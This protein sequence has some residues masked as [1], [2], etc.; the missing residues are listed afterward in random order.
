MYIIFN[1]NFE[2]ECFSKNIINEMFSVKITKE[3][4]DRLLFILNL[5]NYNFFYNKANKNYILTRVPYPNS[6][7]DGYKFLNENFNA[8]TFFKDK[9]IEF[10]EEL[11]KDLKNL[12]FIIK[13]ENLFFKNNIA[14]FK[15]R[16][17]TKA[18]LEIIKNFTMEKIKNLNNNKDT[19]SYQKIKSVIRNNFYNV[20]KNFFKE[21][22]LTKNEA[23]KLRES[24]FSSLKEHKNCF[25]YKT[26]DELEL[27]A[28]HFNVEPK[29]INNNIEYKNVDEFYNKIINNNFNSPILTKKKIGVNLILEGNHRVSAL[30]IKKHKDKIPVFEINNFKKNKKDFKIIIDKKVENA[31]NSFILFKLCEK[32]ILKDEI[33]IKFKFNLIEFYGIQNFLRD[34][35]IIFDKAIVQNL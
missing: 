35:F 16:Y 5:K 30:K 29:V 9:I 10:S 8:K 7:W 31:L 18:E 11:K 23:L 12:N 24:F 3:E 22:F 14:E 4:Y 19:D 21:K 34:I 33:E 27:S 6:K 15:K 13:N 1:K 25:C 28:F 26:I 20:Q 32:T 17:Y 2:F